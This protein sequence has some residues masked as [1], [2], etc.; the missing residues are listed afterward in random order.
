MSD[1]MYIGWVCV[2][3]Y[4]QYRFRN[5]KNEEKCML[6][7]FSIASELTHF[8]ITT[9]LANRGSQGAKNSDSL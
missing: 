8:S 7:M 5:R 2:C 9:M 1:N 6:F 3:Q 4:I